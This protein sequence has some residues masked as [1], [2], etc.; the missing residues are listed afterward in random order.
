MRKYISYYYFFF[1]G[2]RRGV[3]C[4]LWKLSNLLLTTEKFRRI[5]SGLTKV[6]LL[7]IV[8]H[9]NDFVKLA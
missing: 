6:L 5:H 7:W 4:K 8:N 1:G 9:G 2:G 3:I